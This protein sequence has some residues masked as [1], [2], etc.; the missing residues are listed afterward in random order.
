MESAGFGVH[1]THIADIIDTAKEFREK[2]TK[3]YDNRDDNFVV[4]IKILMHN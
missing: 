4:L 1:K 3:E 2:K